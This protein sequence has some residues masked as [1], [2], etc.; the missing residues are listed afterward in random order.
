[1]VRLSGDS[2][3]LLVC[4]RH[5]SNAGHNFCQ[6]AAGHAIRSL[7]TWLQSLS[8]KLRPWIFRSQSWLKMWGPSNARNQPFLMMIYHP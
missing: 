6:V 7:R 1:M 3:I 8:S 4:A 2:T 5:E